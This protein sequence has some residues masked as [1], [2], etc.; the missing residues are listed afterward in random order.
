MGIILFYIESYSQISSTLNLPILRT[1]SFSLVT[2]W[3]CQKKFVQKICAYNINEIDTWIR[4]ITELHQ[5]DADLF[6]FQYK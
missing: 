2:F 4:D 5:N 3:L 6:Q 1:T